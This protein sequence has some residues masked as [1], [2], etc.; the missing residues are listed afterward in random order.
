MRVALYQFHVP[1][2]KSLIFSNAPQNS[3]QL[4]LPGHEGVMLD[5]YP[6]TH[7]FIRKIECLNTRRKPTDEDDLIFLWSSEGVD[8][9]KLK[10]KL[11][12]EWLSTALE[13]YQKEGRN[14]TVRDILQG[15]RL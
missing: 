5:F 9:K 1:C 8:L 4:P 10:K 6:I 12:K 13:E 15:I 2:L 7:M 11:P 14:S 3:I